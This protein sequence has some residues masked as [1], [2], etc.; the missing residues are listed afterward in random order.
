MLTWTSLWRSG[1]QRRLDA[2]WRHRLAHKHYASEC[3]DLFSET[4]IILGAEVAITYLFAGI[5]T[6]DFTTACSW[7]ERFLQRPPDGFPTAGEAVWQLADGRLLYLVADATRAG[8]ALGHAHRREPRQVDRST[9]TPGRC[10]LK[11]LDCGDTMRI[12]ICAVVALR[13]SVQTSF[14]R[15]P[16]L[17]RPA[18]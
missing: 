13:L 10:S 2:H 8:N 9:G 17:P 6:A 7:Y 11:R 18:N 1:D 16:S 14:S 15:S 3:A 5:P 12:V 4:A